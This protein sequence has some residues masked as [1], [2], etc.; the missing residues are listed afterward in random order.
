MNVQDK[1]T[2]ITHVIDTAFWVATYRAEETQRPD[3]LFRDPLAARLTGELGEKISRK[4][5]GTP[6]VRWNV[7]I[8]TAVIDR[9]IEELIN[10]GVDTVLNLGAGLDTR[11]YRMKLPQTLKWMEVD[12]DSTIQLKENKLAG[13]TPHCQLQRISLDLA[14]RDERQKLFAKI[15]SESKKVLVIT[16]GVIPYLSEEQVRELAEDLHAQNNFQFWLV[17]YLAPRLYSYFKS[18]KRQRQ[19]RNAPFKFMPADWYGTFAKFGWRAQTTRYLG[20]E[21]EKLGRHFPAPW[22][23]FIFPLFMSAE[24]LAEFKKVTG[25][26][27]LTPNH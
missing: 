7:V 9:Y 18:K 10:Q 27:L 25:F 3:A 12:Y 15:N 21:G 26:I 24:R 6:Y 2:P 22:W 13:E 19:M 4:M 17:E 16:E 11:P 20:E 5:F 14:Q 8:R 23:S 1:D